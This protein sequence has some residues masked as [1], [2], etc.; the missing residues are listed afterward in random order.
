MKLFSW[1]VNGIRAAQKKGFLDWL[2]AEK[3]DVLTVQE[4]KARPEQLDAELRQ[5]EGYHTWWVS[6]E[7]K[8]Y[9]GVGLFSRRSQEISSWVWASKSSTARGG[10]SSPITAIS[11]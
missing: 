1:N 6:A 9:S 4:T 3:P 10:R 8:G 7:R 5:P 11:R 2:H